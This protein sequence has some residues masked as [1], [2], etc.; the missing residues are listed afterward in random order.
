MALN[1][2]QRKLLSVEAVKQEGTS[3]FMFPK[4]SLLRYD[5]AAYGDMPPLKVFWYDGMKETP[6]IEGVPEGE[7]LGDPP[8]LMPPAGAGGPGGGRGGPG[9]GRRGQGGP[10]GPGMMRP[11]GYEFRSPGRVFNQEQFD[12]MRKAAPEQLRFP[13]PDG[14]L[15]IGDKGML[16]TG[17]YGDVTRLIPVEKMR[18]YRMP[19]PTLTRSPGHM[20]DFI[21]ACKGGDPACS[22][23]EVSAPFT[24]WMLLGA[25]ALRFPGKLEWDREKMQFTNNKEANK[26]LKPTFR[27]G[28]EFH[29]VKS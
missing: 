14:S 11:P 3:P 2:S 5:F 4:A 26:L 18:D 6:K 12:A 9:G 22:N 28:W 17:T 16:T 27:K 25:I 23:F 19:A 20:L 10:G 15:F 29:T 7:W 1:L 24:E 8:S 21:R 13:T